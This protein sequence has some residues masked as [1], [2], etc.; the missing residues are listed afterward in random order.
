MKF[1]TI[2]KEGFELVN[3]IKH[4]MTQISKSILKDSN[5]L[6]AE[7]FFKVASYGLS[8]NSETENLSG[9]TEKSIELFNEYCKKAGIDNSEVRIVDGSGVSKNNL[10]TAKF[11]TNFL[12]YNA[13]SDL[14]NNLPTAGEGTLTDRMLYLK[15]KLHAKTG[16]LSNVSAITG[17]LETKKKNQYAFCIIINNPKATDSDMKM[18]EE[19]ILR[20]A[21]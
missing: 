19:Y 17:Y 6:V 13:E 11:M 8:N 18:L 20:Y 3:E 7:S 1:E 12:D 21:Y 14:K 2:P 10:L 16:T 4:P 9:T 15:N 5:N